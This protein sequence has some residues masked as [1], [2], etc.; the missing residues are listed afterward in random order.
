VAGDDTGI[1][2]NLGYL[3]AESGV[4]LEQAEALIRGALAERGDERDF[5]DSLGWA[6]YKQGKFSEAGS[7][8]Q[9]LLEDGKAWPSSA[10]SYDHAGD[11]FY[12]LG[13]SDRAA[14][15]WAQAVAHARGEKSPDRAIR[16]ILAEAPAKIQAARTALTPAVAPLGGG[17]AD[18]VQP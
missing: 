5:L 13:W 14:E 9:R 2:N 10:V 4:H 11:V 7:V 17:V 18:D 3:Y 12:R 8:F 16:R 6:L 1:C 15:L